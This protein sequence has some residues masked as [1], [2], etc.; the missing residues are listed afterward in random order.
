M[1]D[2]ANTTQQLID[3]LTALRQRVTAL[4]TATA[5]QLRA[6]EAL[7][8]SQQSLQSIL[9]TLPAHIAI[10]DDTGTIVTVNRAWC[11][12]AAAN[13]WQRTVCGVGANY[14]TLCDTASGDSA[15]AATAMA[16]GVRAVI[17]GQQDTFA[18]EY[19]CHNPD[20]QRWFEVRATRFMS[21]AGRRIVVS[22]E[23][24]SAQKVAEEA[25]RSSEHRFRAIF[26]QQHQLAGIVS[27]DGILLEVNQRALDFS[28]LQAQEVIGRPF[29]DTPWW[30]HSPMLQQ[31]LR[32]GVAAAAHG[33]FVQFEATHPRPDGSMATVDFSLRPITDENGAVVFLVPES[34]DI[35][36]RTQAQTA[37]GE[38]ERRLATLVDVAQRLTR[39]LD[40]PTV[41][42]AIADA[43]A[44]VF[45]GEAGFHLLEGESLVRMGATPG[46]KA[47]MMQERAR[48][49]ESLSGRV[50]ASGQALIT[51]HRLAAHPDNTGALICVPVVLENRVLGTLHVFRERGHVF[52]H[53]EFTMATSLAHQA[54]IAIANARLFTELRERQARLQAIVDTAVDSI[55]TIDEQGII[56]TCN[57]ATER[58]FGYVAADMIGQNVRMLMPAPY[59]DQHDGYLARHR[60]TGEPHIIGIGRQVLGQRQD[61]T[62]FPLALAVSETRFAERRLFTGIVHDLTAYH[63]AQEALQESEARYRLLV[64]TV[65]SIVW[66]TQPDGTGEY[67]NQRWREYSGQTT[68]QAEVLGRTA[69]L[70]PDDRLRYLAAWQH[71][72]ETAAPYEVEVRYRRHDGVYRW[73]LE[74]ALPMRDAEGHLVKWLGT[75]TDIEDKKHAEELLQQAHD[76][77]ELRVQERTAAN[78]ELRRF[79]YIVSHDLRAPLVNIKGF[80]NE[81]RLTYD[82]LQTTL[83]S[84]LPHLDAQ[85]RQA[86]T[87]ALASDG[88]EALAFIDASVSRMDRLIQAVLQLSRAGHRAFSIEPVNLEALVHDIV[89]TLTHQL[90]ERQAKVTIEPLPTIQADRMAIEQI[91]GNLLSNAVKY[92]KP[93]RPG[94]IT[95]TATQ[96]ATCTRFSVQDNG[97]GIASADIP[98]VFEL[99]RRV[100]SQDTQGEGVGLTYVQTL[101]RRHGGDIQCQSTLDVGTTFTLTIARHLDPGGVQSTPM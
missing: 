7:Q 66:M 75:S 37:L 40:L 16:Q 47:A 60:R 29:W 41:L 36:E 89:Q 83:P 65:P 12:F 73:F 33:Q 70:H 88:P 49:G 77:L 30:S 92:L 81:L 64:D 97:R 56:D 100:G 26:D 15:R 74:R 62:T 18:M 19:P 95:I 17:N 46:A 82:V 58:L 24:M 69:V 67:V 86:V 21:P 55:I 52:T 8:A 6:A 11:H 53:D 54:A 50:A 3:E 85:Q 90:T 98:K 43:A 4:E 76:A 94:N 93:G 51:A 31:L 71:A 48:L 20:V 61:G 5:E 27:R 39:G 10:L 13:T 96:E 44:Q 2:T 32:A 78:G 68:E 28:G 80:T 72:V 35:T 42:H 22:H 84:A 63:Q 57:A 79:A 23:D 45:G 14:L 9:D 91:F 101:V 38:S 25:L 34:Q 99:F 1:S 59:R 87:A